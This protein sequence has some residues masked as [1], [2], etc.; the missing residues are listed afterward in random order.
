MTKRKRQAEAS[1]RYRARH[2]RVLKL[3]MHGMSRTKEYRAWH[4]MRERCL[5]PKNSSFSG[6]GGRGITIFPEWDNFER[7]FADMGLKP[8]PAH[9]LDRHPNNNGNYEP[10]NCRWATDKEQ[11]RNSRQVRRVSVDGVVYGS[12]GEAA[13][14]LRLKR[15]CLQWRLNSPNFPNYMRIPRPIWN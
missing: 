13:E 11:V 12:I 14:L 5:N 7:F 8:S 6:Y 3:N 9:S 2:P 1:A 10:G 4:Q 15:A